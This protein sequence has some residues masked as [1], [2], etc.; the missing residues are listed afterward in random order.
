MF[1]AEE[2]PVL[3]DGYKSI[4]G[5]GSV[6]IFKHMCNRNIECSNLYNYASVRNEMSNYF[7][8]IIKNIR[9]RTERINKLRLFNVLGIGKNQRKEREIALNKTWHEFKNMIMPQIEANLLGKGKKY[10]MGDTP[11]PVD[12]LLY[13]EMQSMIT[14]F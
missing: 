5:G 4:Y 6:T 12:Y 2:T 3:E 7:A 1:P 9:P 10:L 8:W 11:T 13:C 14:L